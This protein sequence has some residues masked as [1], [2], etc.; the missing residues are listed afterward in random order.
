MKT[1]LT[2]GSA[3]KVPGGFGRL[4]AI[5]SL[6]WLALAAPSTASVSIGEV[7]NRDKSGT[8]ENC[9]TCDHSQSEQPQVFTEI[10]FSATE[11]TGFE[12]ADR[13]APVTDLAN[14]RF[15]PLSHLS[16]W[17][18]GRTRLCPRRTFL[19]FDPAAAFGLC[20]NFAAETAQATNSIESAS[21][22]KVSRKLSSLRD[23]RSVP[24]AAAICRQIAGKKAFSRLFARL[25]WGKFAA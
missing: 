6:S 1:I 13:V 5:A 23:N 3:N 25:T 7:S 10:E 24:D 18:D 4:A 12:P 2:L 19:E 9:N 11:R 21:R 8:N 20:R 15:R 17:C 16:R 22:C 14:R